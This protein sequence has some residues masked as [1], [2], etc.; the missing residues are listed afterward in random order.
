MGHS[1]LAHYVEPPW[2]SLVEASYTG[3][4]HLSKCK[5]RAGVAYSTGE[6]CKT[7]KTCF[8]GEQYCA[9][10]YPKTKCTCYSGTWHCHPVPCPYSKSSPSCDP[11]SNVMI[12]FET[13]ANGT[14]LV[15]AAYV[16]DEWSIHGITV[17][18]FSTNGGFTPDGK[19]RLF[20]TANPG[21]T[22]NGDPDLG[23]PNK[24][25]IPSGPG[26]G[27]G[28]IP[29]SIGANCDPQG[30]VLIVQEQDQ[31]APD[32]NAQGGEIVFD[33][34]YPTDVNSLGLMDIE[35]LGN[36]TS[37]VVTKSDGASVVQIN[38]QG[39]GDNSVENIAINVVDAK[40]VKINFRNS[41]AVTYLDLCVHPRSVCTDF[42]LDFE[43]RGD[44][45]ALEAGE[46][47]Q[48]EWSA[49]Y[50][51]TVSAR[52][53]TGFTPDDRPRLFDTASP[54]T[55]ANGD[56]DL[57]SPNQSCM[58]SG[59]G[60]GAGGLPGTAGAN[61][62]PQ[63]LV[64]IV[65]ESDKTTPDDNVRG[66]EIVFDFTYPTEVHS[67][68]LMDIEDGT[69]TNITVTRINGAVES[70]FALLGLGDNSVQDVPINILD[71][72]QVNITFG[73]SGAVT[74]LDLCVD[75]PSVP[76][77]T[78]CPGEETFAL[79]HNGDG[80]IDDQDL[81]LQL[82]SIEATDI[83]TQADLNRDGVVD[84]KDAVLFLGQLVEIFGDDSDYGDVYSLVKDWDWN[85]SPGEERPRKLAGNR[86]NDLTS[87]SLPHFESRRLQGC[88]VVKN[89]IYKK[90]L[91]LDPDYSYNINEYDPEAKST[92]E[93]KLWWYAFA[94][95]KAFGIFFRVPAKWASEEG[96]MTDA[97]IFYH[98]YRENTGSS[99][100]FDF[101]KAY[102]EDVNVKRV[103]DREVESVKQA[104]TELFD[105][106][107]QTFLFHSETTRNISV[108]DY[109][110]TINWQFTIG[111]YF[112]WS[113]GTVDFVDSPTCRLEIDM[114][115]KAGDYYNFNPGQQDTVF[116]LA[117]DI[118]VRFEELGWAKGFMTSGGYSPGLIAVD[119]E[120]CNIL[121]CGG[122]PEDGNYFACFCHKCVQMPCSAERCCEPSDCGDPCL[123]TCEAGECLSKGN[124]RFTLTWTGNDDYDL[125]VITPGGVEIS[126]A[127]PFDPLSGGELD[128]DKI[129][130]ELGEWVENIYFP[131]DG[132]A[133]IGTYT[134][135]VDPF[136]YMD[137]ADDWELSVWQGD[138]RKFI[139]LGN[140]NSGRFFYEHSGLA[141]GCP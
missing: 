108:D 123:F 69:G 26:V 93:D 34:A 53:A 102:K 100:V 62:A 110:E 25:C 4:I 84:I 37:V 17:S 22:A 137:T 48:H 71:A 105:G 140:G 138:E 70:G 10:S 86:L 12:D 60:I 141:L 20:D 5:K 13:A 36:L 35:P 119:L 79:D 133:L 9:A 3:V 121:D 120:C 77:M 64:L 31:P 47:V 73:S 83:S 52:S 104:A 43:K 41:G 11:D 87:M 2:W 33:F 122:T 99:F 75:L 117:D 111:A 81:I 126:Y 96:E 38:S 125:H 59:P 68:G 58:P 21:T 128:R 131:V 113:E 139:Q 15:A 27:V 114:T 91:G 90:G 132:S 94:G 74:H 103:V 107:E 42:L 44:E 95:M 39:F 19:P 14:P 106:E 51:I 6:S 40:Q 98:H 89:D 45:T 109:P 124:P 136:S 88:G 78:D 32:D 118:N 49:E 29:T 56:P 24:L 28:G 46:Y 82:E 97:L 67:V 72:Q 7:S 30:L 115:V 129:P 116:G 85:L 66:G 61:C 50:G 76:C 18:A 92:W 57:G 130:P 8:F 112:L 63:G 101:D 127:N 16:K 54:G 135:F 1:A 134:F 80:K 65:Q 55:V 23:S